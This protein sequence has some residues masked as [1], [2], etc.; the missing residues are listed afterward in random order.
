M[1]HN[2]PTIVNSQEVK[3]GRPKP[4][5][6]AVCP[7]CQ[8]MKLMTRHHIMPRRIYGREH[9][10]KVFMLC[11]HCHC[12]LEKR[13][14]FTIQPRRFYYGVILTFLLESYDANRTV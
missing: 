3:M 9:N 2:A 11:W 6:H 4:N 8:E 13:I 12:E 1:S 5:K 10:S 7:K 14:P